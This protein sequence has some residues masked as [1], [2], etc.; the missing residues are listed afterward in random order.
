MVVQWWFYT[1]TSRDINYICRTTG[2]I[3]YIRC[4]LKLI[5]HCPCHW[6]SHCRPHH[7]MSLTHPHSLTWPLILTCPCYRHISHCSFSP[8][9][10]LPSE[11]TS[12]FWTVPIQD[13]YG[14]TPMEALMPAIISFIA[15]MTTPQWCLAPFW[16]ILIWDKAW[17]QVWLLECILGDIFFSLVWV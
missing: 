5:L 9:H 11:W 16:T 15:P 13:N 6:H 10:P 4:A 14:G 17:R 1:Q 8:C 3:D 12:K 2:D 7:I